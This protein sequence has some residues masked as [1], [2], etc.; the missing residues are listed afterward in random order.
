MGYSV[1]KEGMQAPDFTLL[2]SDKNEHKLIDYLNKKVI[3]YF[4]P[5]DSTSAC[6]Q[7]AQDLRIL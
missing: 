2:G 6:S 4:Y 3:L 1:L 5:K 7:E